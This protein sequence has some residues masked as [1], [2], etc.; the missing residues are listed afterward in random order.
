MKFDL[1]NYEVLLPPYPL[2]YEKWDEAQAQDYLRWFVGKIPER[3]DYVCWRYHK[4]NFF[5]RKLD[6]NDPESLLRIW[7]WFLPRAKIE[8]MP[9]EEAE[10]HLAAFSHLG[11]TWLDTRQLSPC[12]DYVMRDIGMLLGHIFI[13]NHPQ[14]YWTTE[15]NEKRYIWRWHPVL[16]G[17]V[18]IV[19][20]KTTYP[21][22][23]PVHMVGVQGSRVL[24]NDAAA[25]DLFN[26]Y[27]NWEKQI[28]RS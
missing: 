5:S 2:E 3:V 23:E 6:P 16:K 24:D 19:G 7:R 18:Y 13:T 9:K 21:P 28:P 25:S 27:E 10:A 17:F 11:G 15:K 8:Q 12:T 20:D 14:L 4:D 26:I 22:F 1:S